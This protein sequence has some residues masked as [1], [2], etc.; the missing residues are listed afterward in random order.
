MASSTMNGSNDGRRASKLDSLVQSQFPG[1]FPETFSRPYQTPGL[2]A[3]YYGDYGESVADQPG[4]RPQRPS[5]IMTADQAHLLEP[6]AEAAPP[7]EPSS[8][9]QVG[10]AASFFASTSDHENSAPA[11]PGKVSRP[12]LKPSKHSNIGASPRTSPG[13]GGRP[14]SFMGNTSMAGAATIGA[15]GGLASQY[16]STTSAQIPG[17][18]GFYISPTSNTHDEAYITTANATSARPPRPSKQHSGSNAALYGAAAAGLAAGAGA[19]HLGHQNSGQG[20]HAGHEQQY[21]SGQHGSSMSMAHRRSRRGPLGKLVNFFRDPEGVAEF[22]QYSEAIGVCRYCFDPN[23]SP[24]DAP[25][26]HHHRRRS[27]GGRYGSNTRVDKAYR[28]HS[29][30]EE[31]RR[32]SGSKKPWVAGGITAY[33][34]ARFGENVLNAKDFDDTYSVRTGHPVESQTFRR[35]GNS[36]SITRQEKIPSREDASLHRH[37]S[38]RAAQTR[39]RKDGRTGELY[40]ERKPRRRRS[41]ASNSSSDTHH[42]LQKGAAMSAGI[43]A[44]GVTGTDHRKRSRSPEKRYYHKRVSPRHSYVDLSNTASGGA[45]IVSFFSSPSANRRKG[46]KSKGFFG[47]ND[48]SSS[49]SDADLAFGEG[50]VRRKDNKQENR[51]RKDEGNVNTAILGLAATGAA[52]AAASSKNDSKRLHKA[53]LVAVKE[54]RDQSSRVSEKRQSKAKRSSSSEEAS[55]WE[56]ASDDDHSDGSALAYGSRLSAQQSRESLGS[57]EGTSKWAWRW[58]RGKPSKT[59][60]GPRDESSFAPAAAGVAGAVLGTAASA[61]GRPDFSETSTNLSAMQ[62]LHPMPTSDPGVFDVT[63]QSLTAISPMTTVPPS[64][65]TSIVPLHHPQPFMP[66]SAAVYTTSASSIAPIYASST[67]YIPFSNEPTNVT[68]SNTKPRSDP[69]REKNEATSNRR[70]DSSPNRSKIPRD[71]AEEKPRRRASTKDQPSTVKFDLTEEQT[72]RERRSHDRD[73]RQ[74]RRNHGED[75]ESR[76]ESAQR[77]L[78]REQEIEQELERL[79]RE[80][81][82][83]N[84]ERQARKEDYTPSVSGVTVAAVGAVAGAAVA[85]LMS[86]QGEDRSAGDSQTR[87]TQDE[88]QRVPPAEKNAVEEMDEAERRRRRM[89]QKIAIRVKTSPSSVRHDDYAAYFTPPEL[90]EKLKEHNDAADRRRTPEPA[91][92]LSPTFIEIAPKGGSSPVSPTSPTLAGFK[93]DPYHYVPFGIR[94]NHDPS[95]HQWPVPR[96]D[97]VEPTPPHSARG[98][99]RGNM[100]PVPP[101]SP[102]PVHAPESKP[103]R[104]RSDARVSWGKHETHEFDVVTP[105]DDLAEFSEVKEELQHRPAGPIQDTV[106]VIVD[107]EPRK[108]APLDDGDSGKE[109][110]KDFGH[111][112]EFAAALAA[113]AQEAGFDPSIVIDDPTYHRRDSPPGSEGKGFYHSPFAQTVSDLSAVGSSSLPPQTGFIEDEL[114]S[115]PTAKAEDGQTQREYPDDADN[116]TN[117]ATNSKLSK[118]ERKR[119]EKASQRGRKV[120]PLTMTEMEAKGTTLWEPE[121][122]TSHQ[123]DNGKPEVTPTPRAEERQGQRETGGDVDNDVTGATIS[124]VSKKERRRLEKASQRGQ[125]VS[126]STM[127]D[128]DTIRTHS[129]EPEIA[130]SDQVD[131]KEPKVPG[132]FNVFDYIDENATPDAKGPIKPTTLAEVEGGYFPVPS[133]VDS[134]VRRAPNASPESPAVANDHDPISTA[135]IKKP[136]STSTRDPDE[137]DDDRSVASTPAKLKDDADSGKKSRRRARKEDDVQD[138]IGSVVSMPANLK[139]DRDSKSETKEKKSGGIFGLFS[140]SKS[141]KSENKLENKSKN[142]DNDD[143]RNTREEFKSSKKKSKRKSKDR[144]IDDGAPA[145]KRSRSGSRSAARRSERHYSPDDDSEFFEVAPEQTLHETALESE[146]LSFLG[147]RPEMPTVSDGASGSMT[148]NKPAEEVVAAPPTSTRIGSQPPTIVSS[149]RS[150]SPRPE[151]REIEETVILDLPLASTPQ[152]EQTRPRR[153][154]E[155][156]TTDL[157]HSPPTTNSTT[158]VP[159]HFRRLPVS[160]G[161]VRSASVGAP[162][163]ASLPSS[164]L[165]PRPRQGRPN[166]TEFR[167]NEFRP[168]WL[169]ERHAASKTEQVEI[170]QS[171]PSLPSSRTSSAHTSMEDLRGSLELEDVFSNQEASSQPFSHRRSNSYPSRQDDRPESPDF[172]DSRTATPTATEFPR[173]VKKEKPKY[174]F[175]SPSELLQDPA[176]LHEQSGVVET[177]MSPMHLPRSLGSE[178]SDL[179]SL[180]PLPSSR[181]SSTIDIELPASPATLHEQPGVTGSPVSPHHLTSLGP[182]LS[183]LR[184]LSPLPSRQGPPTPE[185]AEQA[186][187][188][189]TKE[190]EMGKIGQG[191]RLTSTSEVS[192]AVPLTLELSEEPVIE[193]IQQGDEDSAVSSEKGEKAKKDKKKE[194][195]SAAET[196]EP[197]QGTQPSIESSA[198]EATSRAVPLPPELPEESLIQDNEQ[199]EEEDWATFGKKAKKEKKRNEGPSTAERIEPDQSTQPSVE[200]SAV[201]LT[202]KAVS[203]PPEL[204][205]DSLSQ[206]NQQGDEG[207]AALGKKRKKAKK[208]K[209]KKGSSTEKIEPDQS[210]QQTIEASNLETIPETTSEAIPMM[211]EVP[212]HIPDQNQQNDD[213]WAIPIKKGKKGKKNKGSSVE[214]I[215]PD[216]SIEQTNEASNLET[217]P[218]TIPRTLEVPEQFP[219]QNHQNDDEWA[220]PI[221]KG[222]KGKKNKGLSAMEMSEPDQTGQRSAEASSLEPISEAIPKTLE[223]AEK[224]PILNQQ[225]DEWAIPIKKGKKGKKNKGLSAIEM[226]EPDQTEHRSAEASSLEPISEAIPKTL[227]VAEKSPIL[228]LQGDEWAIPIKKGK[229]GK[230]NKG[231]SAIEM[232]EP[233]QTEHRSAEASS[234]EPISEAIPK[235]LEVAEKSPILN[236]QGDERVLSAKEGKNVKEDKQKDD[237]AEIIEPDR[238]TRPPIEPTSLEATFEALPLAVEVVGKSLIL[239]QQDDDEG[240]FP[241][242]KGKKAKMNKQKDND[243]K[244]TEPDRSTRPSIEPTSLEA[245]F[246]ALPLAINQQDDE[247]WAFPTKKEKKAKKDKQ[248]K[249]NGAERVEPGQSIHQLVEP[250]QNIQQP[251]E[252]DQSIQQPIE[253][254]QSIQRPDKPAQSISQPVESDQ[255]TQQPVEPDQSIHQPVE[256]AQSIYQ[257]VE[258]DQST[259]QPVEPDQSIQQ[260]VEPGQ[261]ICQPVE[262]DQSIHQPVEHAQSIQQPVE[263]GQSTQ[264]FEPTSSRTASEVLSTTLDVVEKSPT[265]IKQDDDEWAFPIKKGKKPKKGKKNKGLG[266][267]EMTRP[268][269]SLQSPIDPGSEAASAAI[270]GQKEQVSL[271]REITLTAVDHPEAK[272]GPGPDPVHQS[273][274]TDEFAQIPTGNKKRKNDK[275]KRPQVIV[276]AESEPLAASYV[277]SSTQDLVGV[278]SDR[279]STAVTGLGLTT[280]VI[281]A[282]IELPKS[283]D[284]GTPDSI[285]HEMNP[286]RS[287]ESTVEP[288][289]GDHG[290][291]PDSSFPEV[292]PPHSRESMVEPPKSD[293][294]GAPDSYFP[295]VGPS[296]S[297]ESAI[298]PRQTDSHHQPQ[299][300]IDDTNSNEDIQTV[301]AE[302]TEVGRPLS[303][304]PEMEQLPGPRLGIEQESGAESDR[305]RD[306]AIQLPEQ[307]LQPEGLSKT[308]FRDSGYIP[309]PITRPGWDET[310]NRSEIERPPRPLTPTSS[311]EDLRSE[312]RRLSTRSSDHEMHR[313]AFVETSP[314][315]EAERSGAD[316]STHEVEI[317]RD[318]SPV[319]STTKDRSS[320]LFDSS[321][322]RQFESLGDET[323]SDVKQPVRL[324]DAPQSPSPVPIIEIQYPTQNNSPTVTSNLD[325][326]PTETE[327]G[328]SLPPAEPYPSIFGP[329]PSH[330]VLERSLSP[331][332]TPLQTIPEDDREDEKSPALRRQRSQAM[333]ASSAKSHP[334]RD[335][336][337]TP[338]LEGQKTPDM[339]PPPQKRLRRSSDSEDVGRTSSSSEHFGG[340]G[341]LLSPSQ[342]PERSVSPS[343]SHSDLVTA[344][345]A[346]GVADFGGGLGAAI[347]HSA[348]A[349][350]DGTKSLGKLDLKP[351][352]SEQQR[353]ARQIETEGLPSSSTYD[354][355]HDKGKEVVRDMADV[356]VSNCFFSVHPFA[357]RECHC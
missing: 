188:L 277:A 185:T 231:F 313:A 263:P 134:M 181:P 243:A 292:G 305:N 286:S 115:T 60:K 10:A 93:F 65:M 137:F 32:K 31:K 183:T 332:K 132:S 150:T 229:K 335:R 350:D 323:P 119:L 246:E 54:R 157:S 294:G 81:M 340:P 7:P 101:A 234:L 176:T 145:R 125:M 266:I 298:S 321:P 127:T 46:K 162:G 45:G 355:V 322:S 245:T 8:M 107:R 296:R 199:G 166:S 9:G 216:Q 141:D 282:A 152:V 194:G 129:R 227:E 158:A 122:G 301:L 184:S 257:P 11:L 14:T 197:D 353:R 124:K 218:E 39:I 204:P 169:V 91:T 84:S 190:T 27:S 170:E 342:E 252:L 136:R 2:A 86:R 334:A 80:D 261:S 251:V 104:S 164:P 304:G 267:A 300:S 159:I 226:S 295:E 258:P 68:T 30:D 270:L 88:P 98:S 290:G 126:P 202:S 123:V 133:A 77:R 228:N 271:D 17:Q 135:P 58:N 76:K 235:T 328:G 215:E 180:P 214:K 96:L 57:S 239:N 182:D 285:L 43:F 140:S 255:S 337:S 336:S 314:V 302:Y 113:G 51:R 232:S 102:D 112:L 299:I 210:I 289:K 273:A 63:R 103:H 320:A 49:S 155:L 196:I 311:S 42:A 330:E 213:E 15:A 151:S 108:P 41:S 248:K 83:Q 109:A 67:P 208:D 193:D 156:R 61:Y 327:K 186:W 262:P 53:D 288:L 95:A 206:D 326:P 94:S 264:P 6:T 24:K 240:A 52:L 269:E 172:L 333:D 82:R 309:S 253:P 219:D 106:P 142:D 78:T 89:A 207:W 21:S 3:E 25:R 110:S 26:K 47:F 143:G 12:N 275:K 20:S 44:T 230:K 307:T 247:E 163:A 236:Q 280:A 341:R 274:E 315:R 35:K 55:A 173:D 281:A 117:G 348:E 291:A 33:G 56:D 73:R 5:I 85:D 1:E 99:V 260:P 148:E 22:E 349:S 256:L 38:H 198:M 287:I 220:I 13:P 329:R 268:S 317:H 244:M 351:T 66:V 325:R 149:I 225:G 356:Y 97:L 174:E 224:S 37:S 346:M 79:Y 160:P 153:L 354:P 318:P 242:K 201:E 233:D 59:K 189:T 23:S 352:T 343:I 237:D 154:S 36:L 62:Q 72:R 48:A 339:I 16:Y 222:K 28:H 130:S 165:T 191:D 345:G 344:A 168:L 105:L 259:Q 217:I 265:Q 4:V 238:S 254:A 209:K 75:G 338:V 308:I 283:G 114:P 284:G 303:V 272:Q 276:E 279:T 116:G 297:M 212:E 249:N 146:E 40:E 147:E 139:G 171:Y 118:K 18:G 324:N 278:S 131:D 69:P 34:L 64:T 347:L 175:H 250:G 92:P 331:P 29:S 205:E 87:E 195:S 310:S 100:S 293:H 144:D 90:H 120:I 111:D 200:S 50:S 306:S 187:D 211:V 128:M 241:T 221:K 179:E 223:V 74:S 71:V 192:K 19:H 161:V 121:I 70:R 167:S 319:D 178:Y 357:W 138:D 177:S 312:P 316:F 203:L